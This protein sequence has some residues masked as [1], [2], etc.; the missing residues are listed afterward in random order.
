MR[1]ICSPVATLVFAAAPA[2]AC[3]ITEGWGFR[4]NNTP[5]AVA[6]FGDMKVRL[7]STY[8]GN[9]GGAP[10]AGYCNGMGASMEIAVKSSGFKRHIVV[11]PTGAE[12]FEICGTT[13]YFAMV[14]LPNYNCALHVT[15]F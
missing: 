8:H 1:F 3:H 5:G 7:V 15:T 4:D 11:H 9:A 2:S 13:V 10:F 14:G 12:H 6:T